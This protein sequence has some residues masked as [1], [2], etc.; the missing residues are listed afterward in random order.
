[1]TEPLPS[2]TLSTV[3][4]L[5]IAANSA[6]TV[7]SSFNVNTHGLTS[8]AQPPPDQPANSEPASGVAVNVTSVPGSYDSSSGSTE[9]E[10]EPSPA[11]SVVRMTLLSTALKATAREAELPEFSGVRR[12]V[13]PLGEFTL[14]LLNP[15]PP[16]QPVD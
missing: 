10:P 3:S 4:T 9:T 1:E 8:G 2:P 13:L 5:L 11:V 12:P 7:V 6:V 14:L 15:V 16:L